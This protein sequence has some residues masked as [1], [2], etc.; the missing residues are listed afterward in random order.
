MPY[1]LFCSGRKSDKMILVEGDSKPV[2]RK[3]KAV[4]A[5]NEQTPPGQASSGVYWQYA[6]EVCKGRHFF[7][8]LILQ[9]CWQGLQIASDY[10]LAHYSTNF[11][12]SIRFITVYSE[13]ALGCAFFVLLKS[14]LT[15]HMGLLTAQSF[16]VSLLG[17]IVRAPM[18]FFDTTQPGRI[19]SR[20]CSLSNSFFIL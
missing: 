17:S 13:L 9:S 3:R 12:S 18:T 20:V 1:R 19:L 15:A 14:M 11:Q 4:F 6:T 5:D 16:F 2:S 10:W 8:F 7:A